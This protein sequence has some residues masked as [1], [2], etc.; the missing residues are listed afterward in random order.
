MREFEL[1]LA[2]PADDADL[3]ALAARNPVPGSVE[4]AY[5]REPNYFRGC[6]PLGAFW[7]VLAAR[8]RSSGALAATACR[9]VREV[10][11]NGEPEAVGYLG[12]LRVDRAFRGRGL[13]A[14]GCR[15]LRELHADGRVRGYL[16]TIV[17][18]NREALGILVEKA[19]P[20][21]PVYR[22][23]V[24]L[25]TLA[26]PAR[27]PKGRLGRWELRWGDR[28]DL[29][30][31]AARLRSEGRS[32]QFFPVV[33]VRE[34]SPG[35]P[36]TP[37]LRAEDVAVAL[38]GGRVEGVLAL[39]DQ[40]EFRQAVV[41]GYRGA[42]RWA[43]PLVNAACRA[44]G[45]PRLPD[46]GEPLR[47]GYGCFGCAEGDDPALWLALLAGVLGR[48]HERGLAFVMVGRAE[49]DPLLAPTRR[50]RHVDY[51]SRLYTAAWDQGEFH[52]RLDGRVAY[53]EIA[54]L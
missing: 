34:L 52:A 47:F 45:L 42:L 33:G 44:A 12:H 46:P 41:R 32:R 39:W 50:L 18:G 6:A 17:E 25:H 22:P 14:G 8:H 23:V 24:R 2:G 36:T 43:R 35:C 27:P 13:V 53:A 40:T 28:V 10:F 15:V 26:L 37:G 21:I 54:T 5:E 4:L 20:P 31:V 19:R 16:T 48:A 3:R 38:R 9:A 11:V 51:A 49:G 30:D 1:G 29:G 7:Q